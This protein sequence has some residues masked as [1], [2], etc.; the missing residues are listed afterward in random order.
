MQLGTQLLQFTISGITIGSIY[1]LVAI[2]FNIIYNSTGIINF[3][4]GEFVMLG[5]MT[6]AYFHNSLHFPI[7][8]S[9]VLAV[10]LVCCLGILFERAAIQ[11]LKNPSIITLII[12][13]IA[14]SIIFKGGAMFI[15][16]KDVHILPPFSGDQPIHL[17][18]ATILPQSLW[19]L[20]FLA[21][22]MA[23]LV[24]FFQFTMTG[25][26]MKACSYNR[27][28]ASIMGINVNRMVLLSFALSAGIGA[29]AGVVVTPIIL[30]EY[31][32]GALLGLKGFGAAIFG[33]L[34]NM[35]GA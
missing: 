6:A 9:G 1:A 18:G 16:G 20:G 28:A 7:I 25:K 34:G 4:Q 30:V 14:A 35:A 26:A 12:I 3:A 29:L 8:L 32:R 11:P 33:G 24:I 22:I 21:L 2:G 5:G 17:F 23:F 15:W 19:V 27:T 13:T 10:V 31:S